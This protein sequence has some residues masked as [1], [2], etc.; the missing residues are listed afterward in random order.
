MKAVTKTFDDEYPVEQYQNLYASISYPEKAADYPSIWVT[1]DVASLAPVGVDTKQYAPVDSG[2]QMFKTWQYTGN[3]SF[4]ITALTS[5]ER[6][7]IFDEMVRVIAFGS[8]NNG[9][10][11]F[12]NTIDNND[13]IRT[14]F[15]WDKISTSG[16]QPTMGTPW[17]TDEIVYEAT[18]TMEVYGEFSSDSTTGTLLPLSAVTVTPE[19]EPIPPELRIV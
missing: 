3:A 13:Y 18:I 9:R 4:V 5:L 16:F 15:N 6:D 17:G 14:V 8:L 7:E 12:R 2:F 19:I 11:T 10:S 1:F